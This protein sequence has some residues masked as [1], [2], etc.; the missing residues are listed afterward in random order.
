MD[1]SDKQR[2]AVLMRTMCLHYNREPTTELMA[3]WFNQLT[4]LGIEQVELAAQLLMAS[5][6][7]FMPN[8]GVL[9]DAIVGDSK[10]NAQEAWIQIVEST[11]RGYHRR[12]PPVF[13]DPKI[14]RALDVIGGY[15]VYCDT[16]YPKQPFLQNQFIAAYQA[17]SESSKRQEIQQIGRDEAKELLRNLNI[18]KLPSGE[19]LH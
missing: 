16:E 15:G 17:V 11:K 2:F 19:D 8:P 10:A 1:V 18:P 3:H 9:R 5:N 14:Q 7:E 13:D 4:D 12:N 6:R